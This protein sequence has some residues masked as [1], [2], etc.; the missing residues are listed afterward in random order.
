MVELEYPWLAAAIRGLPAVLPSALLIRGQVGVGKNA[1]ASL[2]A[3]SILCESG[4]TR[5]AGGCGACTACHLF[6]AGTHPDFRKVEPVSDEDDSVESSQSDATRRSKRRKYVIPVSAIRDLADLVGASAYRGM[7]KVV[8][9]S[10]AEAMNPNA[11]NALL[12]MLEEPPAKSHFMLV[13]H[14]PQKLPATIVSRCFQLPMRAP[15]MQVALQW[16]RQKDARNSELALSMAAYAPLAAF[17]LLSDDAY[18]KARSE[19]VQ[20][21]AREPVDPFELAACAEQLEPAIVG[22]LLAMWIHDVL[23]TQAGAGARFHCDNT[24]QIK[25]LAEQI[26]AEQLCR[27]HDRVLEYVRAAYHPLNRRLALE[28]LFT[29][30][31]GVAAS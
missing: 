17:G 22:N 3:R 8:M 12:K 31:P 13:S 5:P 16:L 15:A 28:A 23:A 1:L 30:Y 2:L 6:A 27:W 21:L 9:I 4:E 18:W 24:R 29:D 11:A 25:R 19:L 20:A 14:Q 26:T 7:G 10:P